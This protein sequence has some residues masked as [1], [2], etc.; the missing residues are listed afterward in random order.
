M[1]RLVR[2]PLGPRLYVLGARVHEWHLGV[3]LLLGLA[4]GGLFDRVDDGTGTA[5]V[6][7]A[8]FWLVA[9][10][11][12]DLFP[13]RRDTAAWRLGFHAPAQPLRAVRR[14][15]PL[16]QVAALIAALAG[17]VN[18]ASAVTPTIAWRNH[19]LLQVEP[20]EALRLSH[21]AAVPTSMLLLVTAPYLWRR[22]QGA[23]RLGLALLLALTALDL[24]K[25][26][27]VEAAAGSAG[28]GVVLWRP[29][30]VDRRA[31][32][33]E[34]RDGRPSDARRARVADR[35]TRLP[36]RARPP[37]RGDRRGGLAR[38]RLVRVPAVPPARGAA[39]ASRSRAAARGA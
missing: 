2:H 28:A 9:K 17:L 24:L 7:L 22:R 32:E 36:R 21:A 20:L 10:D 19:L 37:R 31:G 23:L 33:R 12:R 34:P 3:A 1:L 6:L 4:V 39:G 11:W 26:L 35:A 38:R 29:R 27:D 5:G 13:T 14:A 8:G 15:D 16:P 30:G 18:L 25:G